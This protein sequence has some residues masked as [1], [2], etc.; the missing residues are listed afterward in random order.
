MNE[1]ELIRFLDENEIPYQRFDHRAVFTVEEAEQ[2]L[3]GIPGA[4]TKNLFLC[5]TNEQ[6]FILLMTLGSKRVHL[7]RFASAIGLPKGVRFAPEAQLEA[8]LGVGRG[9]V[10]AL[11]VINDTGGQVELY[12]DREL[13][14]HESV[15]CH[16]LTNTATLVIATR[17]LERFFELTG[18]APKFVEV[19]EK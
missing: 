14:Q 16:P 5:D 19:E 4:G 10:T 12:V 2:A 3:P 1:P 11:G 7:K 13:W 9:G 6:R 15:H 18:H 17:D 8:L